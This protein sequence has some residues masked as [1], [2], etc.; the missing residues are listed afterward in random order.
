ML[1]PQNMTV[2]DA[3][4]G[5]SKL[6]Q[7]VGWALLR[8]WC[9]YDKRRS[10]FRERPDISTPRQTAIWTHV[11]RQPLQ[12]KERGLRRNQSCRHCDLRLQAS[13][14]VRNTFLLFK[15]LRQWYFVMA[16]DM[17]TSLFSHYFLVFS[18]RSRDLGLACIAPSDKIQSLWP[19][20]VHR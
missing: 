9:V 13:R 12:A 19:S 14:N 18:L 4:K 8:D 10:G 7:S 20:F 16:P 2:F 11:R 3:F 1:G 17:L 6:K 5:T 15:P